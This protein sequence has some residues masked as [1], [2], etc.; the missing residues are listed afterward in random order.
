MDDHRK[1]WAAGYH[2]G[3][4]EAASVTRP[5]ETGEPEWNDNL[6]CEVER[7]EV[8]YLNKTGRLWMP[9]L[10]CCD[11]SGCIRWFH[12]IDDRVHKIETF[13]GGA[14]DTKYKRAGDEWQ[15]RHPGSGK[16]GD[17]LDFSDD[18]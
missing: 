14:P 17:W 12:S 15:A 13:S 1:V 5:R 4:D 10:Q 7:M 8:D 18:N 2:Q 16:M 11:M 3:K 9:A 6:M